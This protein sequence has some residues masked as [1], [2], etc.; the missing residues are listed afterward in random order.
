MKSSIC[1]SL[2]MVLHA[3]IYSGVIGQLT[4][5][6]IEFTRKGVQRMVFDEHQSII[7]SKL[8]PN[9]IIG[10]S[11]MYP[12]KYLLKQHANIQL[13]R[14]KLIVKSKEETQTKIWFGGFNPFMS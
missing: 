11:S 12:Q 10:M 9:K 6:D 13:N 4:S 7:I 5:E 1:S 2:L 3:L 14:G 8:E